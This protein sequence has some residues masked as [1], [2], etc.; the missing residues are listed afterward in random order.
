MV[1]WNVL[2]IQIPSKISCWESYI[3]IRDV[4]PTKFYTGTLVGFILAVASSSMLG[5]IKYHP[6]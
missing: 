6:S 3:G 5:D 2:V 4:H 1:D